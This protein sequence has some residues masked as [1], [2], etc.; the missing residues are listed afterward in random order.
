MHSTFR[1]LD[2]AET[3][4]NLQSVQEQQHQEQQ[5]QQQQQQHLLD[6]ATGVSGG[7]SG[8]TANVIYLTTDPTLASSS[9]AVI[10]AAAAA[11]HQQQS[12]PSTSMSGAAPSPLASPLLHQ[13][14]TAYVDDKNSLPSQQLELRGATAMEV[15]VTWK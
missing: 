7:A 3:L 10:A 8:A 12:N 4:V 14:T 15:R 6:G 9:A 2:A 11:Q 1:I 13:F 5:Q